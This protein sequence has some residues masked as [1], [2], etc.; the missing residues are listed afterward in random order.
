MNQPLSDGAEI[1]T[2]ST[3]PNLYDSDGDGLSDGAEISTHGTDPN[4]ADMDSDGLTDGQE[5]LTYNT[6]PQKAD[7]DDDGFDDLF[8]INTGYDPKLA[9]STPDTIISIYTAVEVHFYTATG[10][11]YRVEGTD[12]LSNSWSTVESGI[13]G[14]GGIITRLYSTLDQPNRFFRAVHE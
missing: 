13:P 8:E 3:N 4:V 2:H 11:V 5:I 12:S 14:N 9:S 7:T 10:S 1:N 6:N